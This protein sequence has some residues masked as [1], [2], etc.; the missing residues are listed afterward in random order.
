[1]GV[2]RPATVF[3]SCEMAENTT[4]FEVRKELLCLVLKETHLQAIAYQRVS[5]IQALFS[6]YFLYMGCFY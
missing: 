6:L 5:V 4:K 1:M 2:I 3:F